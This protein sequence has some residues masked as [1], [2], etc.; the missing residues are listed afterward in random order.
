MTVGGR[1]AGTDWEVPYSGLPR[2]GHPSRPDALLPDERTRS[3]ARFT[4]AGTSLAAA[5]VTGIVARLLIA[6]PLASPVA[7][8]L[9]VERCRLD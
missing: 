4:A 9:A 8:V 3:R 5:A 1:Y 7:C 2:A 6:E